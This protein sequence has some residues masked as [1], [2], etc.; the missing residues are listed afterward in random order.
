MGF[1]F[2]PYEAPL[3]LDLA[4]GGINIPKEDR[5]YLDLVDFVKNHANGNYILAGPDSPE[6]Y[7]LTALQNPTP[8]LF[9]ALSRQPQMHAAEAQDLI[10]N[11]RINLVVINLEPD[12]SQPADPGLLDLVES[13]YPLKRRFGSF[14]V[15]W[16]PHA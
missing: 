14:E 2:L 5:F 16:R 4:R 15:Y 6:I 9:E 12:F 1:G 8:V 13:T 10:V 3:K 11:Y 7:F